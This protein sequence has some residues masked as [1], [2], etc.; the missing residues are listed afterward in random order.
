MGSATPSFFFMLLLVT[1]LPGD[2]HYM[3]ICFSFQRS[4]ISQS[5]TEIAL[6]SQNIPI[7]H[8][9][10]LLQFTKVI[11]FKLKNCRIQEVE[12]DAFKTMESLKLV[13]LSNNLL[14]YLPENLFEHNKKLERVLLYNNKF[15]AV[16]YVAASLNKLDLS[17]N[18][19][20][21]LNF[22]K[23]LNVE[24]LD[25]GHNLFERLSLKDM[26]ILNK[27]VI[28]NLNNNPWKCGSDFDGVLCW[29]LRKLNMTSY[30][31]PIR[32]TSRMGGHIY[33]QLDRRQEMCGEAIV[34]RMVLPSHSPQN[35][36]I[37][38]RTTEAPTQ[39][40]LENK[41]E[42]THEETAPKLPNSERGLLSWDFIVIC[43]TVPIVTGVLLFLIMLGIHYCFK[44]NTLR[45][46]RTHH[47]YSHV[48]RQYND[49]GVSVRSTGHIYEYVQ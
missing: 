22:T 20:S 34:E 39:V 37:K 5:S 14:E 23:V 11:N 42:D 32:C 27:V 19:I 2:T 35:N 40:I 43:I 48:N 49:D 18:T 29:S 36:V 13:D 17:R 45:R 30:K 21:S 3:E 6:S 33:F 10:C 24:S 4:S 44:R 47:H 28:L 9:R 38:E 1:A 26:E 25:L 31:M 16:P 8:A 7:L 15:T 46:N 12:E 41:T